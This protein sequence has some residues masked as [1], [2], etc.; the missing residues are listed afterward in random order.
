MTKCGNN[1]RNSICTFCVETKTPAAVYTSMFTLPQSSGIPFIVAVAVLLTSQV[2]P[3]CVIVGVLSV[4]LTVPVVGV[5][6][7]HESVCVGGCC[8]CVNI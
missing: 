1:D 7:A 4:V 2:S 6:F 3:F 5:T 8:Y